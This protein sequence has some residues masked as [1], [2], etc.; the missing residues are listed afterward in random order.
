MKKEGTDD[1]PG[2]GWPHLFHGLNLAFIYNVRHIYPDA[3]NP[4]SQLETD[5]DDAE[6]IE[7]IIKYL[8]NCGFNVV[9][10]E[11]NE[12]AYIKLHRHRHEIDLAFNFSEGLHGKTREAQIPAMLEMLKIP[13]TGSSSL[14][15]NI[16]FNKGKT[17]EIFI[18]NNIATP[19]YQIFKNSK[20][21]LKRNLKFPLIVKPIAQGSSAGITN[22]S[23]VHNEAELK[24]QIDFVVENFSQ[25]A[26]V[27]TF[28]SGR[29]FSIAML[30]NPPE[31][32]SVIE[33]RHDGLPENYQPLDSLEVKWFFEETPEGRDNHLVCPADLSPSLLKK[34]EKICFKTW[35]ALD[36]LDW[37]RIDLRC[38]ENED[39]FVLE[40]N[41]P[42]GLLPPEISKNSYY[43]MAAR[44]SGLD[45]E[46]LLKALMSSSLKRYATNYSN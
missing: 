10:I 13:Y 42:A 34:I 15:H 28:L 25:E 18:A 26:I 32:L 3:D 36:I 19:T 29:E 4:A 9:P 46:S 33:A 6:T 7:L 27:E 31:I 20:E 16:V 5:F 21:K 8:E 38:N 41:T 1:Q 11:A 12:E 23:V 37:C 17:K 24:D 14:T 22:K 30:G 40:V 35:K 43:P 39:V 44:N 45:Y 2:P